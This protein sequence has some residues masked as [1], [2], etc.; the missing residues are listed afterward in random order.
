[1][2][3][4]AGAFELNPKAPRHLEKPPTRKQKL[5]SL[6]KKS[7]TIII[8]WEHNHGITWQQRVGMQNA[9]KQTG[10]KLASPYD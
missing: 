1:M 6:K 3:I 2:K 8:I 7:T 9:I 4:N 10:H 5:A